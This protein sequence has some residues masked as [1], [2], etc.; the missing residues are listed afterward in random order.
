MRF[1]NGMAYN[2]AKIDWLLTCQFTWEFE[3]RV[4]NTDFSEQRRE[5]DL[6][7]LL[8]LSCVRLK[9][10]KRN[11]AYYHKTEWGKSLRA[12]YHFLLARHGTK[13]IAPEI[14]SEVLSELW[15]PRGIAK[16]EPFDKEKHLQV[17]IYASKTEFDSSGHPRFHSE[18]LSPALKSLLR[19]KTEA[20]PDNSTTSFSV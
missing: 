3:S 11:L 13:N 18:I 5:E 1:S 4:K 16:I 2:L 15:Q 17:V 6:S 8:S 19:K 20:I 7:Q 14:I 10:R 12:H 9:L